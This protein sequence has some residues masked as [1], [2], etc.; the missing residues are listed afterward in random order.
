MLCDTGAALAGLSAN[1]KA[2][3]PSVVLARRRSNILSTP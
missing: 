3:L 2:V 1:I